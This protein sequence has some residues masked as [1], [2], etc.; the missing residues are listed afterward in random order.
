MDHPEPHTDARADLV[1]RLEVI[2]AQP[3]PTRAAAYESLAESLS[4]QLDSGPTAS[5]P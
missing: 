2:E 5:R 4:R 1:S 3:L